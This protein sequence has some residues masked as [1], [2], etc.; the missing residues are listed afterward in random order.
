[1]IEVNE[2]LDSKN[3]SRTPCRVEILKVLIDSETALSE[4]EI[5]EQLAYNYDRTTVYRTLRSFVSQD[6]IH[7]ISVEGKEVRYAITHSDHQ[8]TSPYHVHFS[9]NHCRGVYCISHEVYEVP[10]IP[11]GYKPVSYDLMI[12]GMCD[13]CND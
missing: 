2:L 7:S 9:C 11:P 13:K 12:H 4:P 6:V 1:M 3:L 5:R 8:A 10:E